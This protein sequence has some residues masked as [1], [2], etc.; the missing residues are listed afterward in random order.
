M[1]W[2]E[3]SGIVLLSSFKYIFG[4]GMA[5]FT[6]S[7]EPFLGFV[8]TTIGGLLGATAWIFWGEILMAGWEKLKVFMYSKFLRQVDGMMELGKVSKRFTRMNR[9]IVKVK[10][11]GGL[12]IVALLGPVL[13]SLPVACMLLVGFG[14]DRKM[15]W[16]YMAI[17]VLGWGV[18]IFGLVMFFD[19]NIS[20][21]F[22]HIL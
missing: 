2:L 18:V 8:F 21:Y 5:M 1:D 20:K 22:E 14:M 6:F 17:S 15:A 13:I 19:I 12:I 11:S 3:I 16:K 10:K 9:F 7:Q 4:V